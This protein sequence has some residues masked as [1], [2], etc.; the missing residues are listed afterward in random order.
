MDQQNNDERE[1]HKIS[2]KK[3]QKKTKKRNKNLKKILFHFTK[4]Y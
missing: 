4:L 1:G 3:N 2:Q